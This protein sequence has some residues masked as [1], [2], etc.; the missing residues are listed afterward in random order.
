[1]REFSF[2]RRPLSP[3]E[4]AA[5]SPLVLAYVGDAVYELIIRTSLLAR[6]TPIDL[7]HRQCVAWV[8][9][10]GQ[11][12]VWERVKDQLQTDELAIARRAR[13]AKSTA[14]RTATVASYRRATAL[15]ALI[16]YLYLTGQEGRIEA[17]I[18]PALERCA[19]ELGKEG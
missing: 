19:E 10:R 4:A 14:P 17:L 13:N 15:E 12:L 18:K 1:M 8:S 9:A 16:G 2:F 6:P 5:F 7:M 11:E 3:E